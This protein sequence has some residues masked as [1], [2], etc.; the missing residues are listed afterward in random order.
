VDPRDTQPEDGELG[1]LVLHECDERADDESG[2]AARKSRELVAEAFSGAGGHDEE[3]VATGGCSLADLLLMWA[4][5]AVTED[6]MQE[7]GEGF[8]LR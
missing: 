2:S 8:G 5:F 1:R 3:H 4:K 6:A 7:L